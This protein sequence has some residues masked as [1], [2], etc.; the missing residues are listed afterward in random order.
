MKIIIDGITYSA[1]VRD[2]Q[3]AV[4]GAEFKAKREGNGSVVTVT[5]DGRPFKVDLSSAG[6]VNGD[7]VL[8]VVDGQSFQVKVE[9][10]SR[11][12]NR[13]GPATPPPKH[14]SAGGVKAVMP[15]KIT[16]VRC[17]EGDS[18]AV[19]DVLCILEAMKMENEVRSPIAGVVK[20]VPI[21]TGSNVDRGDVLAV[22]E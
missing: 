20:S 2:G 5:V 10:A 14:A 3:V 15:G 1:D 11:P 4:D 19:G 7:P 8:A 16:N 22:V 13:R 12:R 17:R 6:V 9:G 21:A 18:V